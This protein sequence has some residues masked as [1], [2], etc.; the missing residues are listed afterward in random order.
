LV[1]LRRRGT[2]KDRMMEKLG[3]QGGSQSKTGGSCPEYEYRERRVFKS[4]GES[5]S[6]IASQSK[7]MGVDSYEG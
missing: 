6:L 4:I 3:R 7:Q 1:V 5:F 2:Q